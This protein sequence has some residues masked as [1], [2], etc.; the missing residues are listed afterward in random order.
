MADILVHIHAA[1]GT[2]LPSVPYVDI[3]VGNTITFTSAIDD[4]A[5]HFSPDLL[6]VIEPNDEAFAILQAG[7]QLSY[8]FVS[9]SSGSHEVILQDPAGPPPQQFAANPRSE[10]ARVV[11]R[12]GGAASISTTLPNQTSQPID[13]HAHFEETALKV[14]NRIISNPIGT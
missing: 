14:E 6:A 11:L 7:Q 12:A 9:I 13:I 10:Q 8:T 3:V 2:R 5:L 4:A 1:D